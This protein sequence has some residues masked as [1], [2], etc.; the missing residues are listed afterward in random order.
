MVPQTRNLD[1]DLTVREVLVYHGRYFGLPAAERES[2]ADRLLQEMQLVDT[3]G[4][5]LATPS[6]PDPDTDGFNDCAYASTCA[7][8]ASS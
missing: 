3:N 1:R 7:A 8:P 2:R 5:A 4:A 6:S